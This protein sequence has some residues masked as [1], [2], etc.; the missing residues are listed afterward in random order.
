[1]DETGKGTWWV[2]IIP[3]TNSPQTREMYLKNT[4][5][6]GDAAAGMLQPWTLFDSSKADFSLKIIAHASAFLRVRAAVLI[7]H[8]LTGAGG[9]GVGLLA[10]D[11]G[12]VVT[13][14]CTCSEI[15]RKR[16]QVAG[17]ALRGSVSLH[18]NS[19]AEN[20]A[21][22][23]HDMVVSSASDDVLRALDRLARDFLDEAGLGR[24]DGFVAQVAIVVEE[25]IARSSARHA[26]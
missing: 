23:V 21:C 20:L 17:G 11:F 2:H 22:V 13:A 3:S 8:G 25:R 5:A 10:A 7:E 1:M 4:L 26:R 6:E 12:T 14:F 18:L 9:G 19:I 16:M 24:R 15:L